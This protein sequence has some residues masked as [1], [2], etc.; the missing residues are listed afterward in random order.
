[1]AQ[2]ANLKIRA[3]LLLAVLPLALMVILATL[4]SS[5]ASRRIDNQYSDLINHDAKT[6]QNLTI[7][8]AHTN[9]IGLFLY[10]EIAE[11][12]PDKRVQ[13]DAELDSIYAD[14]Q[15]RIT[16]ALRDSPAHAQRIKL[17]SDL[18][19]KA[20]SDAR[21]IRAAALANNTE[22]AL[23]LIRG[24]AGAEL[25]EA[26]LAAIDSV[27]ELRASVDRQSDDLSRKTHRTI[28]IT[29]LVVCLGLGATLTFTLY[30]VQTQV[31]GE[32]L[33]VRGSV[34][35]LADGQLDQTIPY[36][37]QTNEIGAIS[38][39]LSTLQVGA[40]EREI[41]HW[42]KAEVSAI[43]EGLQSSE[44][45]AAFG[46]YLFSRLSQSIALL[47]GALYVAD[48]RRTRLFR[49]SGFALD[50]PHEPREFSFGEGLVG[51]AAVERRRLLVPASDGDN[52]HI[53]TGAG[54][55]KPRGLIL[56]PVIH[57]DVVTGVLELAR[58]VNVIGPPAS[59]ARS[60]NARCG[61]EL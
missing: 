36:L 31:I 44:D 24:D 55:V 19:D 43:A 4:Y 11:P 13:I 54:T 32:L 47:Y 23:S 3:K 1:M 10:E 37:N 2:L 38:R 28:L 42:V 5:T 45:F 46:K 35:A 9:R 12:N 39:A 57:Q 51:Q 61:G 50:D 29:W 30:I 41:Q 53:S 49:V 60:L 15:T 20:M 59:S 18:F 34:Q 58:N 52:L 48:E 27:D 56:M 14:F 7:A 33:A 25:Q 8:R 26:R 40:R 21:P 16:D 22:K 6:L 17:T